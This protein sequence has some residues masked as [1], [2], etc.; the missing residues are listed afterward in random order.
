MTVK[1]AVRP[2]R[3]PKSSSTMRRATWVERKRSVAPWKL[4]DVE[5]PRVA[6]RGRGRAGRERLVHVDEVELG[7]IEE[8]LE[9]ARHVERQ[10]HRAAAP[11][12]QA[13][14][15]RHERGAARLREHRV[16]VPA[17]LLDPRAPVAHQLARVGGRHHHDAVAARAQLVGEPLHE[18]VDLVVQL[19][20]IRGDL[21]DAQS[22]GGHGAQDTALGSV[23]RALV[24]PILGSIHRPAC[25][26]HRAGTTVTGRG[27]EHVVS[28]GVPIGKGV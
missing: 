25:E 14:P 4:P 23:V 19:P 10:R 20:R 1:L 3:R 27:A 17:L 11:E 24:P 26:R 13:L 22:V 16:L 8:V 12:R 5:R 21:G 6:Q 7:A 18:A 9:R 2:S 15:D 28:G